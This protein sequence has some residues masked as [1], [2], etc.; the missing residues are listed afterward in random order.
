LSQIANFQDRHDEFPNQKL[1]R[2]LV[3][4]QDRAG[5]LEIA[6]NLWNENLNV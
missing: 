4:M 3:E 6:A 5:V 2:H 1:A